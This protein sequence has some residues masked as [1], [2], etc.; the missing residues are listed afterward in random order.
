MGGE[1]LLFNRQ[2]NNKL[3]KTFFTFS[4]YFVFA[5]YRRRGGS[6]HPTQNQIPI[7]NK[8]A[9]LL[10]CAALLFFSI[11]IYA[12]VVLYCLSP[13]GECV[14]EFIPSINL[15]VRRGV[16]CRV[17]CAINNTAA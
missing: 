5:G 13:T 7:S 3:S 15:S 1:V 11:R 6:P 14:L 8:R 17:L 4:L 10:L 16:A 9:A 2:I 12:S